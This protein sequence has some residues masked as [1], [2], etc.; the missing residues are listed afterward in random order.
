M[1]PRWIGKILLLLTLVL[2]ALALGTVL[3]RH[4]QIL[5]LS[6]FPLL[7]RRMRSLYA[8]LVTRGIAAV[9]V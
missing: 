3:D 9:A 4:F 7:E 6:Q 5:S 8:P 1:P 2:L